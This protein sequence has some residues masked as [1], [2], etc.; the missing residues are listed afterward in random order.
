MNTFDPAAFAV[1]VALVGL[2]ILIASLTSGGLERLGIPAVALF[3]GVGALLGPHVLVLFT[4][5]MGVN[6]TDL[7]AHLG[8]AV[9]VLGPGTL[10]S[11]ALTTLAA[12]KL[13]DLPF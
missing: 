3:L 12:W 13:L 5:A 8:V 10:L 4:D 11:A 1:L 6:F 2:V 9:I 7:K